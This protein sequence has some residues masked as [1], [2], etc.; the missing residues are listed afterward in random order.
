MNNSRRPEL[1]QADD[2]D[3]ED[4]RRLRNQVRRTVR[5]RKRRAIWLEYVEEREPE[6]YAELV[7]LRA[8][9]PHAFRKKLIQ[10]A[11]R[12]GIWA[13]VN[14]AS[15]RDLPPMAERG[16]VLPT[17]NAPTDDDR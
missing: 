16:Y 10:T 5:R 15:P 3:V 17:P 7:E 4:R 12:M 9:A 14:R 13:P 8:R 1:D 2:V 11:R 6:T